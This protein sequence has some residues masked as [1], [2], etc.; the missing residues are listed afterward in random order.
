M[1]PPVSNRDSSAG[2]AKPE[3]RFPYKLYDMLER[4]EQQGLSDVVS[5]LPHNRAFKIHDRD[6]FMTHV[7]KYYFEATKLRSIQRQLGVWGFSRW[8]FANRG[9]FRC[10]RTYLLRFSFHTSVLAG[11]ELGAATT[12]TRGITNISSAAGRKIWE[13][14][15]ARRS[16]ANHVR[17][18]PI[19]PRPTCAG[20]PR[21]TRNPARRGARKS[22]DT[23]QPMMKGRIC[24]T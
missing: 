12:W 10:A 9:T 1:V 22:A 14:C 17:L 4:V 3:K 23:R 19:P 18:C 15:F 7:S 5:W 20:C 13:R 21:C 11:A 8:V 6:R 16:S 24:L 2:K